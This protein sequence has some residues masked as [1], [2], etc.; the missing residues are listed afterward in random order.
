MQ[1]RQFVP[2]TDR[3]ESRLLLTT[4][5]APQAQVAQVN[6]SVPLSTLD[7]RMQRIERLP[8]FL[9]ALAPGRAIP[10]QAIQNLQ[11]NLILLIGQ[12]TAAPRQG[13]QAFN[14]QLRGILKDQ[15]IQPNELVQ[16][17]NLFVKNL[18]AARANPSIV[19][20]MRQSLRQIAAADSNIPNSAAVVANDFSLV[21][22][23]ALAV[24]KPL[25]AMGTPRLTPESDSPPRGDGA[26][27]VTQPTYEGRY[28]APGSVVQLINSQGT[29]IYGSAVIDANGQYR[30]T[31]YQDLAPG[32]YQFKV[33]AFTQNGV[34]TL[35]SR[36]F[37]LRILAPSSRPPTA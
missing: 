4:Q 11:Q 18:N 30:V 17:E 2:W 25:P 9:D 31:T 22:Q 8:V 29:A 14:V 26:T 5:A 13:L 33:R 20:S 16:L 28:S 3:L 32:R 27:T 15:S 6:T 19:E 23:L 34:A 10:P 21:L 7:Q 37:S 12:T 24:G 35:P 36:A 1:R